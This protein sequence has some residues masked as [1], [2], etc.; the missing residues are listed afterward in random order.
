MNEISGR[1]G[2]LREKSQEWLSRGAN[3]APRAL[4]WL[5]VLLALAVAIT[6]AWAVVGI[7]GRAGGEISSAF[8]SSA[9]LLG[10]VLGYL[11]VAALLAGGV[12][13]FV[14]A[15]AAVVRFAAWALA[16]VAARTANK[17]SPQA[18]RYVAAGLLALLPGAGIYLIAT[19]SAFQGLPLELRQY[20]IPVLLP[21]AVGAIAAPIAG[22]G[23]ALTLTM[24]SALAVAGI[25][26]ATGYLS[27]AAAGSAPDPLAAAWRWVE[28]M[29]QSEA[30]PRLWWML[31][32]LLAAMIWIVA[33]FAGSREG[34]LDD[35]PKSSA[36]FS[37]MPAS[38][39][40]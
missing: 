39:A 28:L 11:F 32:V 33:V 25:I 36:R 34:A 9:P 17:T 3:A 12:A 35:R 6:V 20:L 37:P 21:F 13:L 23:Q 10:R 1:L 4:A 18:E 38:S 14:V 16:A 15:L 5:G 2:R 7:L 29:R 40:A 26:A 31:L 19:Q 22:R 30:A 27:P 24:F 8:T